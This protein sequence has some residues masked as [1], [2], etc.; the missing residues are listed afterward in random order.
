MVDG[1]KVNLQEQGRSLGSSEQRWALAS[2]DVGRPFSP[3]GFWVNRG[4]RSIR[5]EMSRRSNYNRLRVLFSDAGSGIEENVLSAQMDQQR[6]IRHGQRDFSFLL[7]ADRVKA[8]PKNICMNCLIKICFSIFRRLTWK[9][10]NW[11]TNR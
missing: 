3:V 10:L 5:H 7:Y 2:K 11:R 8:R 6:C 1:T 4:W 9:C